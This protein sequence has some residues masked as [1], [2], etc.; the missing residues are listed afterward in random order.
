[1]SGNRVVRSL[2]YPTSEV[3]KMAEGGSQI[4]CAETDT[5]ATI[6]REVATIS[7]KI[8]IFDA[9]ILELAADVKSLRTDLTTIHQ[10]IDTTNKRIDDL[11]QTY[12][13]QPDWGSDIC[14]E[15]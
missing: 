5:L 1:M 10:N 12:H 15:H 6:L 14:Q 4:P 3:G 11:E 13:Q 9:I 2:R 8:S 7:S